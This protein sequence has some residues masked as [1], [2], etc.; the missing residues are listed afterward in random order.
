MVD[1]DAEED[2][3]GHGTTEKEL[4]GIGQQHHLRNE[5][6]DNGLSSEG[7]SKGGTG[8]DES[9]LNGEITIPILR[10]KNLSLLQNQYVYK[11]VSRR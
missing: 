1:A 8:G 3:E 2:D 7:D 4:N 5:D 11:S 9:A 10:G 6:D